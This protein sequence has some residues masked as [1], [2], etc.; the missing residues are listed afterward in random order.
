KGLRDEVRTASKASDGWAS[1]MTGQ[2]SRLRQKLNEIEAID[3]FSASGRTQAEA[4]LADIEATMR[5][6]PLRKKALKNDGYSGRTWVTRK[7][8]HIDRIASAWLIRR[9]VDPNARFKF[10]PSKGYRPEP[11]EIRFD[12]F[13]AEFTHE[14]NLCTFEVLLDRLDISD[15]ALRPIAESVHDID[16]KESK[17]ARPETAG[18]SVVIAAVCTANK[19]D[20]VRLERGTAVLDDLYQFYKRR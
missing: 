5:A 3:F 12:M 16:F 19:E 7:G 15:R 6:S 17:F 11:D 10:V 8:I 20:E 4:M 9:F 2:L 14:G 18:I 1:G 13:D